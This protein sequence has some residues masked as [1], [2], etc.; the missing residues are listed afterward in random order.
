MKLR[1]RIIQRTKKI[2]MSPQGKVIFDASK[3]FFVY[4][5]LAA[6]VGVLFVA[7][8]QKSVGPHQLAI[9]DITR[10]ASLDFDRTM[11]DLERV[12]EIFP[13]IPLVLAFFSIFFALPPKT[14]KHVCVTTFFIFIISSIPLF[15]KPVHF[16]VLNFFIFYSLALAAWVSSWAWLKFRG[17]RR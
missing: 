7:F 6:L 5:L 12:S 2:A 14:L 10:Y 13:M 11:Q 4:F 17:C 9:G 3:F 15:Q 1:Y 16:L 8:V